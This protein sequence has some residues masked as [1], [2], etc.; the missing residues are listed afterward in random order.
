MSRKPCALRCAL[1]VDDGARWPWLG[2]RWWKDVL[3]RTIHLFFLLINLLPTSP[4]ALHLPPHRTCTPNSPLLRHRGSTGIGF[5]REREDRCLEQLWIASFGRRRAETAALCRYPCAC[6]KH[7]ARQSARVRARVEATK[8]RLL[9]SA[10]CYAE[11]AS[12]RRQVLAWQ[13]CDNDS[14][15]RGQRRRHPLAGAIVRQSSSPP[16]LSIDE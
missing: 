9:H 5:W 16:P 6:T 2:G 7:S 4:A 1:V 10:R 11:G 12:E 13:R 3:S 8:R 15:V 14:A